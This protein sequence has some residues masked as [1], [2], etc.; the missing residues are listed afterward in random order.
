M[1]A[2]CSLILW[3]LCSLVLSSCGPG[4]YSG[5]QTKG[6][7]IRG[8]YYQPLSVEAALDY[9]ETGIA[10]W[11]DES[12]FFGFVR[13][14]TS[15]GEKVG[16]FDISGAHKTLPIPCRVKVT[17]LENGKSLKMRLNDRGPFI[18]GRII[19]VTPRAAAKLGFKDQ[20][21]TKARVE[22]LSVGDGKYER[23]AKGRGGW[24]FW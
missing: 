6:Y 22:V 20:G 7:S 8:Q 3:V 1:N 17:N 24:W 21:L 16:R 12:R 9:D 4:S 13:G 15:L 18:P 14:N 2:G 11:Y 23:K 5:Y 19:D 10:S